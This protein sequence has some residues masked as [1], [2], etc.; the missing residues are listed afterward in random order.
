[1]P[2][3]QAK[4]GIPGSPSSG[5][6]VYLAVGMLR[7]P[8]GVVGDMLMEVYTDFPE[9]L[10]V[11]TKVYLGGTHAAIT[12]DR[13]RSHND[14]L[15]VGFKGVTTPEAAGRYRNTLVSVR[16][17][18]RPTLPEGQY[19]HHQLIGLRVETDGGEALGVLSEIIVTGANDVYVVANEAGHE[20]LLPAIEPVILNVDLDAGVLNVHLIPGLVESQQGE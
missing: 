8:H 11:G 19:Y 5:E 6:P 18:D 2:A 20:L 15:L 17:K 10:R 3:S 9:R 1:M 14:G 13:V 4:A 7:R 16:A 12:L